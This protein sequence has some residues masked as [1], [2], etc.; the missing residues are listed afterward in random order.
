ME[1]R[2]NVLADYEYFLILTLNGKE[3]LVTVCRHH[4]SQLDNGKLP[5]EVV[6]QRKVG[7]KQPPARKS[8]NRKTDK[9]RGKT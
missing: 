2:P 9:V 8:S 3:L 6:R 1:G 5:Y 4:G 7:G